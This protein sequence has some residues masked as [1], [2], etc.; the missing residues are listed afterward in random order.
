MWA[1]KI[2]A[3]SDL[4]SKIN[5]FDGYSYFAIMAGLNTLPPMGGSLSPFLDLGR[6]AA[7]LD[8]IVRRRGL[9]TQAS[10]PHADMLQKMRAVAG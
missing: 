10:P 1:Y 5:V 4:K 6:S 7:F 9:A 8:E 2:P 3:R